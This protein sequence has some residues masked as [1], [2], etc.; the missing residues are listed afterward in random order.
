MYLI[1]TFVWQTSLPH[2]GTKQN[3][4]LVDQMNWINRLQFKPVTSEN[5]KIVYV[6]RI[7]CVIEK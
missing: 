1:I 4:H 5:N 6:L 2:I 7:L 3:H